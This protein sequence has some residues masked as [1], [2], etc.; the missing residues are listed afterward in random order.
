MDERDVKRLKEFGN[1]I[2]RE[3]SNELKA[4]VTAEEGAYK[5]QPVYTIALEQPA[6]ELKYVVLSE[7]ISQGQRV[8]SF[9]I[10]AEFASGSQYPLYQGTTIG[11]KKI[12]Q[13]QDPFALQNPLI[14]DSDGQISRLKVQITAARDE[15]M[16]KE[17]KI[18]R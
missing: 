1:L 15:V 17:I 5:T 10:T 4:S 2:Q 16:M 13:L 12:C 18:Y 8:E 14:N 9:R 3:F 7:D 6:E 11:H